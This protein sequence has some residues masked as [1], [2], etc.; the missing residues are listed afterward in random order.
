MRNDE[1]FAVADAKTA[2]NAAS[3]DAGMHNTES[4]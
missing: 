4:L 1:A 2:D 3:G